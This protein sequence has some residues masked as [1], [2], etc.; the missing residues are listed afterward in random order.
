MTDA[1]TGQ[2]AIVGANFAPEGWAF[3]NGQRLPIAQYSALYS[4]IGHNF[5]PPDAKLFSL[6]NLMARAPMGAGSGP[7]LTP[8][9][10]GAA[11]G[12]SAVTLTAAQL[13]AH[14]HHLPAA[15]AQSSDRPSALAPA[16]GGSYGPAVSGTGQ[17]V[18]PSGF[19]A[20]H[21]NQQPSLA[22]NFIICLS[23]E[24]PLRP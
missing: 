9:A 12:E 14:S 4:V 13:P 10:M 11:T 2:I 8:R 5:G 23:G 1:F 18:Q 15:D 17:R 6:P 3:C 16:P 21:D 7:G 20:A 24:Y 22:M 19:S